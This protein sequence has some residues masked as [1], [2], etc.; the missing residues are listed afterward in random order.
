[1][2]RINDQIDEDF[3]SNYKHNSLTDKSYLT[4]RLQ[5]LRMYEQGIVFFNHVNTTS[6]LTNWQRTNNN[7]SYSHFECKLNEISFYFKGSPIDFN[8]A[9]DTSQ[10]AI[11][12]EKCKSVL[13]NQVCSF[14]VDTKDNNQQGNIKAVVT[15]MEY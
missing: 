10:V 1:M 9:I 11:D 14:V 7:A 13:I 6:L 8:V 5:K 2:S 4:Q 15:S 3:Y 12:I